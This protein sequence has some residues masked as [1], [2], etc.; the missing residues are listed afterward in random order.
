MS[1]RVTIEATHHMRDNCLCLHTQRAARVLARWFDDAL[2][3]HGLTNAQ[4]SLLMTLNRPHPQTLG[5]ISNLLCAD[6]TTLTAALK[7]LARRGLV[8]V[9]EDPRDRRAREISLT[10]EGHASLA[11]AY[12]TWEASHAAL[13]RDLQGVNADQLRQDLD[14]LSF[15]KPWR[16]S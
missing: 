16:P 3:P 8:Y 15:S 2:R 4:F 14:A 5:E 10:S 12:P 11:R 7:T 13:E 1:E 6:R 9:A